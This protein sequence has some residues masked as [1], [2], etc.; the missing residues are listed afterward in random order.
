MGLSHSSI[1]PLGVRRMR[2]NSPLMRRKT[3]VGTVTS[4][5]EETGLHDRHD[6]VT[7]NMITEPGTPPLPRISVGR[8]GINEVDT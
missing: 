7:A 2:M 1:R 4:E 8:V 5:R 6:P 3:A